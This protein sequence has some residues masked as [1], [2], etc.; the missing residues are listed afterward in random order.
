MEMIVPQSSSRYR[1]VCAW[2]IVAAVALGMVGRLKQYVARPSYWNDEAAVVANVIC[3]DWRHLL[4]RLDYAQAAPP[5]FLWAE[6]GMYLQFGRGEYSLR[7]LPMLCG[8][9]VLP[10]YAKLAWRTLPPASACWAVGWFCFFQRMVHGSQNVKQY[11][12][13][14]LVAVLLLLAVFGLKEGAS[15]ARKI[16]FLSLTAAISL[17]F[18]FPVPFLFGAL[19]LILLPDCVRGGRRSA[20][21][22]LCGNAV[23]LFSFVALSRIVLS[24]PADP[25]LVEF[26]R[27]SFPDFNHPL[28]IPVWLAGQIYGLFGYPF[29]SFSALSTAL[30]VLGTLA[31]IKTGQS[32]LVAA[33]LWTFALAF[34]AATLHRYPFPGRHRLGLYLIPLALLIL[35]AGAEGSNLGAKAGVLRWWWI[36]PLPLLLLELGQFAKDLAIR[37]EA[38]TT[39]EVVDYMRSHRT[40]DEPIY[41]FGDSL[42]KSPPSGRSAE[43]L[44]YWPD[45]PGKVVVGFEEPRDISADRFWVVYSLNRPELTRPAFS[46]QLSKIFDPR[47]HIKQTYQSRKQS[48]AILLERDPVTP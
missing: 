34:L 9:I 7:L 16:L 5:L 28:W 10:L 11:S 41:L 21:A 13:D 48:G 47:L 17:W 2:I 23:V 25:S 18:S 14:V 26:W 42:S 30:A 32:K 3:R 27:D 45:A 44:C 39:R 36:L 33:L 8:L 31:L 15:A 35:G 6:R 46:E 43:F 37:E 12:G 1:R 38:S 22:W 4:D 24:H 19:S 20:M 40:M 29:T